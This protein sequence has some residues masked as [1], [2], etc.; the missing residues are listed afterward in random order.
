[1]SRYAF[2][3]GNDGSV[4]LEMSIAGLIQFNA[5]FDMAVKLSRQ[6]GQNQEA[7]QHLEKAHLVYTALRDALT[8]FMPVIP[9]SGM[10]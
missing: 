2:Y 1:M 3:I 6:I 7:L 4:W 10:N 5:P 9:P 8:G